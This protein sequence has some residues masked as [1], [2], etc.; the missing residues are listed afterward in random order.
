MIQKIFILPV[1]LIA[2]FSAAGQDIAAMLA[3]IPDSLKKGAAVITHEADI[4]FEVTD[5]DR[6]YLTVHRIFTVMN[7]SGKKALEFYSYSNASRSLSSA[8][9]KVFDSLGK[10]IAKY[11]E[12]DMS[13]S[14]VGEGLV[15]DGKLTYFEAG[16][17]SYPVTVE[18][19]YEIKFKGTLNYPPYEI[20]T[21][22]EAVKY[23]SFTARV[24]ASLDLRY[25]PKNIVL[26][27][28]ISNDGK[29]KIYKWA[30]NNLPAPEYEEGAVDHESK[31]P[32]V[33]LAPNKFH[34]Y[35]TEGDM[36]SW[37]N[38]G[39]WDY[40]LLKDLYDLPAERKSFFKDLVKNATNDKEK[41]RL[42]YN[43][44]Q[45]NFRYVS[46][47]LGIGGY[48]PFAASFTD[49]KKY[50]DCKGLSFYTH[51]VLNELGIKNYIALINADYNVEPVDP[52]FPCNQFNHV[53]L[54]AP[55]TK[56]TTWLECTSRTNEFGVLGSFTEN[57]NALLVTENG[58][59]LVSTPTSRYTDNLFNAHT[60]V[61]LADDLSGKA[62]INI[63]LKGEYKENFVS[64]I[65]EKPDE[66][67]SYLTDGLGIKQ[68]DEFILSKKE[69]DGTFNGV[70]EVAIEK[71]P[72][73]SAGSKIFLTKHLCKLFKRKLPKAENRRLDFYF[74][75]PFEK[76][77][78]T[79]YKLP[80]NYIVDVL[81]PAKKIECDYASYITNYWFVEN[82]HALYSTAKLI[83]KKNKIPVAGYKK[84]KDFFDEMI[85]DDTQHIVVK[86]N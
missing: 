49:Q 28:E 54:C 72:E 60:M 82:E 7:V 50:G 24:P 77:D 41:M 2:F 19:K 4:N 71:I 46:I 42:V 26:T 30:V 81:P 13:S 32:Q 43:Y 38:F 11:N 59:V 69:S 74:R 48:K 12:K 9:I 85:K 27:P 21:E 44:L 34:I 39:L 22:D 73:F 23:S 51:C 76:S 61:T 53:I 33:I 62:V 20:Q 68:P 52:S 35:D 8:D 80:V 25:K 86:K 31:Y 56:D 16:S 47:Q 45:K 67:K 57:R 1:C 15:P 58:G 3:S 84:V 18:L 17:K 66:Q 65:N 37:K 79:V 83:L 70:I 40:S 63:G 75:Y 36:T 10:Q 29:Y 6:A 14:A 64:A 55:G 5:I 78:T